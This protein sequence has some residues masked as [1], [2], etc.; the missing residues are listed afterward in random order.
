[1]KPKQAAA[2]FE[3]MKNDLNLV[4]R[5]LEVMDT[6]TRGKILGVMDSDVAASITKIMNPEG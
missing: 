3:S 2:I 6:D 1:M 4:A 5:I